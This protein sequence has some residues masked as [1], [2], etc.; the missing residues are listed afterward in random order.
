MQRTQGVVEDVAAG[1]R[2]GHKGTIAAALEQHVQVAQSHHRDRHRPDPDLWS[3]S[4][5]SKYA[6]SDR[7]YDGGR[8][9]VSVNLNRVS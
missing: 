4:D 8:F 9:G 3:I 1:E 7:F 6:A 5:G 2:H